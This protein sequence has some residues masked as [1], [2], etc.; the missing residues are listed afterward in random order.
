MAYA[1]VPPQEK[2]Q[3]SPV[4]GAMRRAAGKGRGYHLT[5]TS[6]LFSMLVKAG[7]GADQATR[8]AIKDKINAGQ[9]ETIDARACANHGY[10]SPY[11][12]HVC[13]PDV[14]GV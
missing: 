14:G 11:R 2:S 7:R 10:A 8:V 6:M 9:G 4:P 5:A 12:L 3:Q 13:S 1:L